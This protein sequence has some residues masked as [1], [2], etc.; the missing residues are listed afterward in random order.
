MVKLN[1]S[2]LSEY[3]QL[4]QALQN[5]ID[6]LS[7]RCKA[8]DQTVKQTENNN[9]VFEIHIFSKRSLTL[10]GYIQQLQ[11]T[12]NYLQDV[13]IKHLPDALIKLEC[14]HFIEQYHVLFKLV[15]GL[16]KGEAKLLYHSYSKPK[17]QIY[18]HLQ[19][20]YQY[21]HR[22]IAMISEQEELLTLTGR[23]NRSYI[24]EKIAAL[25]IRYEKCNSFTQKL[26]FKL[27]EIKDE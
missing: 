24:K 27:D 6:E 9:F 10:S 23:G 15:Q 19:K 25:K 26:E 20:Q 4:L 21:E 3:K 5:Q 11:Q 18:Q 1:T 2:H 22:L 14:E 7:L 17:E 16:E 12:Y 13:I 8:L